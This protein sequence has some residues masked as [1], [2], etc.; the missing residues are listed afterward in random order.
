MPIFLEATTWVIDNT[1]QGAF[2]TISEAILSKSV[3]SGDTILLTAGQVFTGEGNKNITINK[4]L[5]L[6][7]TGPGT[8][9]IID[10]ESAGRFCTIN[11]TATVSLCNLIIRN[12]Q[13]VNGAGICND[14]G[15]LNLTS[16]SF[17]NN[18]ALGTQAV[19]GGAIYNSSAGR[20]NISDCTFNKNKSGVGGAICSTAGIVKLANNTFTENS[21]LG[22]GAIA[23]INGHTFL[24]AIGYT[25]NGNNALQFGGAL[26]NSSS[27][28]SISSCRFIENT[29]TNGEAIYT[30]N[31]T[32][33]ALNNWWGTNNPDRITLFGETPVA[34]E[35]YLVIR[36]LPD[37]LLINTCPTNIIADFTQ[38][39]SGQTNSCTEFFRG[40]VTFS[41][42]NGIITPESS[43]IIEGCATTTLLNLTNFKP[44]SICIFTDSDITTSPYIHCA[45]ASIDI[46]HEVYVSPA[47]NDANPGTI[48]KPVQTIAKGIALITSCSASST[49]KVY[50]QTDSIFTGTGNKNIT[51]EG[52]LDITKYGNGNNPIIDMQSDGRFCTI[53]SPAKVSLSNLI[54]I[55]GCTDDKGGGVLHN[56]EGSSLVVSACTFSNN[57]ALATT[58]GGGVL[59]NAGRVA[60]IGST[61]VENSATNGGVIY[62]SG[63]NAS[64]TIYSSRIVGNTAIKE[65]HTVYNDTKT[66][67][68]VNV[69]SNWWGSNEDPTFTNK[70][71]YGSVNSSYWNRMTLSNLTPIVNSGAPTSFTVTFT[72]NSIP[73][74]T[75]VL[76]SVTEGTVKPTT[77]L[78]VKGT[79]SASAFTTLSH[80]HVCATCDGQTLCTPF[81]T[82][83]YARFNFG[84]I[85][86]DSGDQHILLGSY[87][88]LAGIHNRLVGYIFNSTIKTTIPT[89]SVDF[90]S[91]LIIDIAVYNT[92]NTVYIALLT[93]QYD[94]YYVRLATFTKRESIFKFTLKIITPLHSPAT[95]IRWILGTDGTAYIVT[96]M[97]KKLNIFRAH[98]NNLSFILHDI[99]SNAAGNANSSFLYWAVQEN[100]LYIIQGYDT[101]KVATYKVDQHTGK[102]IRKGIITDVGSLFSISLACSTCKNYLT[103]GGSSLT[104]QG[105]LASY[106]IDTDGK[107][108]YIK[109]AALPASIVNSCERCCCIKNH[110]LVATDNGLYSTDPDS[111]DIIASN[112][113][114]ANN[115]WTNTCWC[116]DSSVIHCCAINSSHQSYIFQEQGTHL[117]K[118]LDL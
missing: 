13:E 74:D 47:G 35:P 97:Q 32:V 101:A 91:H 93:K 15:L 51:I 58:Q 16:C 20:L 25:F 17:T 52:N 107:L 87:N 111:F 37:P 9:P 71:F 31:G 98:L 88:D 79:C 62:N 103:L 42:T 23:S 34:Y 7:R 63:N 28:A 44:F 118:L 64:V 56:N 109:S 19:Y 66:L 72:P 115:T 69:S 39:N 82:A 54:I 117:V 49:G 10:M 112:T 95:K 22:G 30:V 57:K 114:M 46:T 40:T 78:T 5:I 102:F 100:G 105:I 43:S 89:A 45:T 29:A 18:T 11:G 36:L 41:S 68:T 2:T 65:G 90:G 50:L 12:G 80:A 92:D 60:I 4:N 99:T 6:D 70:L 96:D 61:I 59:Y 38:N 55:N 33:N 8:H 26:L 53:M 21:S 81:S 27:T 83:G 24:H 48:D 86:T 94:N 110:L 108:K 76:F 1:G 104:R 116:C 113:S 3:V 67:G 14:G 73:D 106:S 75:P 84:C 77:G 85:C